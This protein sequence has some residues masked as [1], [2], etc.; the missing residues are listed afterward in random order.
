MHFI[1]AL[2]GDPVFVPHA[3]L[4]RAAMHS[5]WRQ[6]QLAVADYEAVINLPGLQ[7]QVSIVLMLV[8][9]LEPQYC[10]AT[11]L[12]ALAMMTKLCQHAFREHI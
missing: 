8:H 2:A 6:D 11:S 10:S 12:L 1:H 5:L 3:L 9:V 7:P 4:L